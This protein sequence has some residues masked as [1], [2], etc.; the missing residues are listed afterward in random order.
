MAKLTRPRNW[1]KEEIDRLSKPPPKYSSPNAHPNIGT[2]TEFIGDTSGGGQFRYVEPDGFLLG[3]ET[4][5]GEWDREKC[6]GGFTPVFSR[7]QPASP[8]KRVLA[9]E[10]YAV[11]AVNIQTRRYVDALQL[12]FMRIKPDGRLDPADSYTSD[13]IGFPEKEAKAKTLSGQGQRVIGVHLRRGAILNSLALVV[14]ADGK[15]KP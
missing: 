10:G 15:G 9:K 12:V 13:W 6:I 5:T 14:A 3:V 11:G 7:D 2:D 4:G 8:L 1:T